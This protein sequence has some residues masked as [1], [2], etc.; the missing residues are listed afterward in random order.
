MSRVIPILRM[1]DYAKAIQFYVD[2]LGF[3]IVWEHRPDGFPIYM[4]ISKGD[5]VIDL[6]E[7]HGDASPGAKII[8]ADFKNLKAFHKEL[9]EKD[10]KYMKP[11]LER[12][13]WNPDILM[14]TVIDP[15]LN[16]IIFEE[17]V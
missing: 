10:Y 15:F 4:K 3:E 2:W 9:T 16:S 7:H 14:M 5:A 13:E 6:S 8:I 11:G 12:A 17:T 1:F